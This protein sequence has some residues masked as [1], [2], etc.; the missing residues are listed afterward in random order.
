MLLTASQ[1]AELAEQTYR[2]PLNERAVRQ[3][4][5]LGDAAGLLQLG[6]HYVRLAP[7]RESTEFH[8]HLMEEE[9]IYV[10]EGR[11]LAEIG[12]EEIAVGP[13]D[14]MGFAAGGA[15]HGLRNDGPEDL[16][17]LVVGQRLAVDVCDYPR[18]GKRMYRVGSDE[19]F[20]ELG[21]ARD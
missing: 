13:G 10:L 17:Y 11:G 4:R 18:A 12:A 8:R 19:H 3:T 7:G 20:V 1:I 5:S 9:C 2:H 14:F 15:A 6:V 21:P 16:V